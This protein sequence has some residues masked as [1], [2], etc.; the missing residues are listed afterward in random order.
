MRRSNLRIIREPL[1]AVPIDLLFMHIVLPYTMHYF[2]PKRALHKIGV[3]LWKYLAH[4]LRL[5]SY[6][7]G[8][9]HASEEYT[10]KHWQWRQ[11]F[12]ARSIEM[13]DSEAEH[14]GTFRR[15]PN[16]DNVAL[17]KNE[18]AT[19]QVNEEGMPETP[20]DAR[21]MA[22]Q[23]AETE[24]AKRTVT[25]DYTI[26]YLPPHF[27][28]R[29]TLFIVGLWLVGSLMLAASIAAPILVGRG[30]FR[31]F[32]PRYVHDG[33]SFFAGF[34]L[35]WAC[36]IVAQTV[37]RMD[38][39]RQRRGGDEP[40]AQL[41]LYVAK[42]S[43]LWVAQIS[44]LVF[45]LG[46]VIPALIATVMEL[47]VIMPVRYTLN[48]EMN[49]RIRVVDMWALGLLY[50]KIAMRAH[51]LQPESQIARGIEHVGFQLYTGNSSMSCSCDRFFFFSDT[52]H[53][54]DT[55]GSVQSNE[56]GYCTPYCRFGRN[57][58]TSS[59]RSLGH[60]GCVLFTTERKL[61]LYVHSFSLIRTSNTNFVNVKSLTRLPY[62]LHGSRLYTWSR[63][64]FESR[65]CMVTRRE[66]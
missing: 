48:P 32:V 9:R 33:Y 12:M 10:Q 58:S 20:E 49:L 51:R 40:R 57:D 46:F 28:Y 60:P 37:D 4:Q 7:F 54:L 19:I 66:G 36:W 34:F 42:R 47:Y 53:W 31:L 15:V 52:T 56:G 41:P 24:K 30:F 59:N 3:H 17:V 14:D 13:D 39:R 61:P 8:D 44:Y 1:S 27:R 65:R 21:L 22:L 45:F 6:M 23:N 29:I 50:A 25:E 64:T 55:S 26:V 11:L 2:R 18:R 43:L 62:D 38:K 5:T 16:T 35:L 63:L